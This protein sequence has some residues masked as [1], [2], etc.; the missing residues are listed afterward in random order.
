MQ[1]V[2]VLAELRSRFLEKAEYHVRPPAPSSHIVAMRMTTWPLAIRLNTFLSN[3]SAVLVSVH[4]DHFVST[5]TAIMFGKEC[6]Q[7]IDGE[8]PVA[9]PLFCVINLKFCEHPDMCADWGKTEG[10]QCKF[11]YY[12]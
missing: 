12:T 1:T 3:L 7:F 4:L 2:D 11:K 5:F 6:K 8:A 9:V 10:Q